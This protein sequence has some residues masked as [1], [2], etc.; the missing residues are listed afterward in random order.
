MTDTRAPRML[1][2]PAAGAGRARSTTAFYDLVEERFVRLVRDNPVLG[3][4]LGLHQDDDLLG[5][6]S[7]EQS[8]PSSRPSGRTWRASRPST[9]P[10]S[11]RTPASSATSRSTT[12]AGPSSIPTSL[13][14]WER[15]SFALDHVGDGLFLLFARDHAPL[16]ERLDAI[17]GRLEAVGTYLE[18][19]KTRAT[20][21]QVRRWQQIE[22]ETAADLPAFF[23]EL[24]AAG[25]GVLPPPSSVASNGPPRRPRSPSTSTRTW[26][27]GTLAGRPGRLGDRAR[28]PRR[29]GRAARRS[30]GSMPT[31]SW[32]SAGSG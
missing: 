10:G 25:A 15:R 27:E 5:D 3:T 12:C 17:A 32:H 18:E 14:I 24:V 20:V 1:P 21:P 4:A 31:R 28:A 19:A 16:P 29:D 30:T 2:R 26:L 23:D 8:S 9:R 6:G 22:I 7:R 13:R 11:P